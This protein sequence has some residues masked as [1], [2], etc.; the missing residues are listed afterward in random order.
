MNALVLLPTLNRTKLLKNFIESYRTTNSIV[1]VKVL[2]DSA[3]WLA[4]NDA[5][6]AIRDTLSDTNISFVDTGTAVQMGDKIRSVW[7]AVKPMK[8]NWVCLLNDDHQCITPE[9]DK[10]T[11]ALIDGTN[12]VS[13]NDGFWNF[14]INVVGLTAWSMPLLEAAGFPIYPRNMKHMFID[15]TWK[16]IG[17]STGCW[18]ETMKIN[19]AHNHAYIG[20]M[21]QDDTFKKVNDMV[22]IKYDQ[23]EFE[24]FMEQDFK[25]VCM[26]IMALREV[27]NLKS[28]LV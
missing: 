25:D 10:K 22:K 19:I 14:G 12:M 26:R 24:H 15:N 23:K 7:T 18:H 13:T 1:E 5:Y 4:N 6:E 2:I 21:E 9:W 11:D 8:L 3:D 20:K 27:H 17:E 16:A 28:K